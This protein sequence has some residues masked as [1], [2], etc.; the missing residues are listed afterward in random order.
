MLKV[1]GLENYPGGKSGSGTFQAIINQIRPHENLIVPFLGN[2]GIVRNIAQGNIIYGVDMS[3]YVI[4]C[5]KAAE[6]NNIEI[7]KGCGIKFTK[8]IFFNN[9]V[10]YCD[11]PYPMSSRSSKR[12]LYEFEMS[13]Q[14]HVELLN[15][16]KKQTC[17][18]LIS[19]YRN[20]IYREMLKDWRLV[21]F[22]SM[23]RNGLKTEYLYCNFPEPKELH[24]YSY[25]GKDFREREKISRKLNRRIRSFKNLPK[26]EQNAF[27]SKI[28][29]GDVVPE[30]KKSIWSPGGKKKIA[31]QH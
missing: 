4:S 3:S 6:H 16:L 22:P 27:L 8:D 11:P 9:S 18:V 12:K 14:Q 23:T 30:E 29:N 2:C 31:I 26:I 21:T 25:I 13:D 15:N 1:K 20:E 17:D 24:D 19:T 28:K 10:I 7:I 5:W